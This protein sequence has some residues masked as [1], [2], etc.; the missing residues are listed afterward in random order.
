MLWAT[1][2][3]HCKTIAQEVRTSELR[4]SVFAT[5]PF[6]K[7]PFAKPCSQ[8][9]SELRFVSPLASRRCEHPDILYIAPP[10]LPFLKLVMTYI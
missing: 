8:A 2:L 4:S 5:R 10:D 1:Q 9:A 6:E 7:P 3:H